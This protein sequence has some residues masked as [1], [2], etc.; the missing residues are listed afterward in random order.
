MLPN[1]NKN[2]RI[3]YQHDDPTDGYFVQAYHA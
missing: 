3:M 1:F 2:N